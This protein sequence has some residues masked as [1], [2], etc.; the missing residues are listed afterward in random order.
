VGWGVRFRRV[1]EDGLPGVGGECQG[2]VR[3]GEVPDERVVEV[4]DAGA[5]EPDV[6][7]GPADTE[8]LAAR[9]QL[10]DQIGQARS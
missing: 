9:G 5:V 7:G 8:L 6:V 10:A 1:R 3:Q 4:L 2:L